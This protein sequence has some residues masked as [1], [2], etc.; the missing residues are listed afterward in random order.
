MAYI[1]TEEQRKRHHDNMI[2]FIEERTMNE[3]LDLKIALKNVSSLLDNIKPISI[4]D[5]D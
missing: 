3:S 2:R 4:E 5:E 1:D